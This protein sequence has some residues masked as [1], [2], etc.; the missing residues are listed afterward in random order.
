MK[1]LTIQKTSIEAY[2][3]LLHDQKIGMQHVEVIDA[4]IKLN[5]QGF[6]G[7]TDN[8]IIAEITGSKNPQGINSYR[9][10]RNELVELGVLE[11]VGKTTCAFSN[12]TAIMWGLTGKTEV[13]SLKDKM[14]MTNKDHP[15]PKNSLEYKQLEKLRMSLY[16][17]NEF[18]LR[19][20][21]EEAQERLEWVREN[22]QRD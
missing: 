22:E 9:P 8:E 14:K 7:A 12:R 17:M 6:V 4:I 13:E 20:I 15:V 18:Q 1:H 10:R 19:N 5:A 2:K 3:Q 21:I 16:Q 11:E